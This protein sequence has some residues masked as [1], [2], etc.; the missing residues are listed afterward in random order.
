MGLTSVFFIQKIDYG[1]TNHKTENPPLDTE[2]KDG[3]LRMDK[4]KLVLILITVAITVAPIAGIL[5]MYQNNLV[6]L[7]VPPEIN[8]ITDKLSGGDNGGGSDGPQ[9]ELV[10][11][12]EIDPVSYTI[13]Q[14][15]K[16]SNPVPFDI[17]LKSLSG[18][19]QCVE[20]GSNIGAASLEDSVSITAGETGT[21]T[22]VINME[23]G[24][25]HLKSLH[26]TEENAEVTLVN[27]SADFSGIQLQLD[28]NMMDQRME[29]PN[30]WYV[31]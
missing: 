29:I 25:N 18:D 7:F 4:M 17:T 5:L 6:G 8:Q 16:V 11:L 31:R 23:K 27:V 3:S 19:V 24:E 15:I 12:P 2:S 30:F 21:V 1:S 13:K 9:V 10:G 26:A 20:H 22:L 14:S 28:Q